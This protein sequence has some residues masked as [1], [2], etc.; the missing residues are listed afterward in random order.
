MFNTISDYLILL[1]ILASTN[2]QR[3]AAKAHIVKHRQWL[4]LHSKYF[5]MTRMSLQRLDSLLL[6]IDNGNMS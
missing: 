1:V 5:D 4:L 2:E 6:A 3:H